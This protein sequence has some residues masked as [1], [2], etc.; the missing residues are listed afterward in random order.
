MDDRSF[1]L[2]AIISGL[3]IGALVNLSNTYYG[4]RA[5]AASQMSM[6]SGLLGFVGFKLFSKCIATHTTCAFRK[7]PAHQCGDSYRMNA[8]DCQI[9]WDN[10]SP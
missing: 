3:L 6:V 8:A 1:T 10:P 2:R 7:R 4:L 5:G 9:Y